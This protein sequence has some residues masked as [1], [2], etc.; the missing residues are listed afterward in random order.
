MMF[1]V[2]ITTTAPKDGWAIHR[3]VLDTVPGTLLIEDVEEPMLI[4]PVEADDPMSAARFVDGVCKLMDLTPMSGSIYEAPAADF[5]APED[6]ESA[7]E[8]P[9]ISAVRGWME[10]TPQIHGHVT[11][12]GHVLA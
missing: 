8:T 3:R 5:D 4:L 9:V 11:E 6:D 10:Q 1:T 2:E 12:D 7:P